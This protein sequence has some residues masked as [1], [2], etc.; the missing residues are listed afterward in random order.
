M[1]TSTT[2][3]LCTA[4]LLPRALRPRWWSLIL[5]FFLCLGAGLVTLAYGVD[6]G[7][8]TR[9]IGLVLFFFTTTPE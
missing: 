6:T 3:L 8:R 9:N 7:R 5:S 2:A 1:A 4:R